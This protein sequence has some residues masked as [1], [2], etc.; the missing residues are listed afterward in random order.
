MSPD[1][2]GGREAEMPGQKNHDPAL[3]T[4]L[5][6]TRAALAEANAAL[7]AVRSSGSAA[8]QDEDHEA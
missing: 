8:P 4:E 7:A 2:V 6:K 1:P 5:A 3:L